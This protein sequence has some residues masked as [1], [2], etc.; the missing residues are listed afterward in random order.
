MIGR[1]G[2]YQEYEVFLLQWET[3]LRSQALCLKL[4]MVQLEFRIYQ[5][6]TLG[7]QERYEVRCKQGEGKPWTVGFHSSIEESKYRVYDQIIY[8]RLY[9]TGVWDEKAH[10][11][12]QRPT[13][14]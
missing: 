9:L 11:R 6:Q 8:F 13:H 7:A 5:V 10:P 1:Q 2:G 14:E 4:P 3:D 12:L